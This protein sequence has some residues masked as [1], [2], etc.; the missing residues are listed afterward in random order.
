MKKSS[1]DQQIIAT[2]NIR[3]A[4]YKLNSLV[5]YAIPEIQKKIDNMKKGIES[6]KEEIGSD[7]RS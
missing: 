5:T 6:L 4:K 1:T 7:N 3:D 2:S